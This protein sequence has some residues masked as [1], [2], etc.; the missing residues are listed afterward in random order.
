VSYRIVVG[1]HGGDIHV[2]SEPGETRFEVR[3]PVD[4]PG[5]TDAVV[6]GDLRMEAGA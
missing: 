5:D 4:G 6:E 3:L 1:R 2:I